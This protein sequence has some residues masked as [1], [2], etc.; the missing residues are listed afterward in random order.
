MELLIDERLKIGGERVVLLDQVGEFVDDNNELLSSEF[1]VEVV[2][3]PKAV[4]PGHAVVEV[5]SDLLNELLALAVFGLL[6][7][8]EVDI[9]PIGTEFFEGFGFPD[10]TSAV[11]HIEVVVR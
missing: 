5:V 2:E 7:R 3:D 4:D 9:R 8:Q 6:G 1:F 10:A 11:D